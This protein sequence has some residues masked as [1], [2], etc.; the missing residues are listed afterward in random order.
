MAENN[1]NRR[2]HAAGLAAFLLLSV[3]FYWKLVLTD[4]YTWVESPDLAH[5]VLPWIQFQAGEWHAGRLPLWAPFEWGGQPL[6]GQG[7]PGVVYPLNW[8]LYLAPL[9]RGWIRFDVL[10]AYY[11]ILHA[12]AGWFMFLL[13]RTLGSTFLASLTGG[14]VFAYGGYLG[15]IDWPQMLNGAIW[16]P[17][18]ILFHWRAVRGQLPVINSIWS[19]FFLGL[20]W[21]SGHHQVPIFLTLAL[22]VS[23]VWFLFRGQLTLYAALAT[24]V[25]FPLVAAWQ[26]LPA[27]EYG[28]MA[29]RWVGLAEPVGW[30][31]AVPYFLHQKYSFQPLSVLGIVI[32]GF[33]VNTTAF[34]GAAAASLTVL[35]LRARPYFAV[36]AGAG[37]LYSLGQ[38]GVIEG[39]LYSLVPMV[40]KARSPSMAVILVSLGAGPMV[41]AG[42]DGLRGHADSVLRRVLIVSGCAILAFYFGWAALREINSIPDQRPFLSALAALGM[43]GVLGWNHVRARTVAAGLVFLELSLVATYLY[44]NR[45]DPAPASYTAGMSQHQDAVD[46]L[47]RTTA[48]PRVMI[49]NSLVPFNFGDWHGLDVYG[50]YLASL[51]A[52]VVDAGSQSAGAVRMMGVTHWLGAG[53]RDEAKTLVYSGAK[54]LNVYAYPDP[55][56]RVW[57][58]H[59][60]YRADTPAQ[61]LALIENASFDFLQGAILA[62]NL[63]MESCTG[64]HS[65]LLRQ[66]PGRVTVAADMACKG[67]LVLADVN[68]PGWKVRVDG[69]AAELLTV[70]G[71]QRG[72]ALSKGWH[73]VEFVYRPTSAILGGALTFVGTLLALGT[74]IIRRRYR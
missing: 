64:D 51:T 49:D 19:G 59:S 62:S 3:A 28:R 18:I 15:T 37:L 53:P 33:H 8:L 67:L 22:G 45:Y 50:G 9:K 63:A 4:Q 72:V 65:S 30:K 46:Y 55:L 61:Q 66:E 27:L 34:M 68:Y 7:Q 31:D 21:L 10:H 6:A 54:G 12:L 47:R 1:H 2:S 29:R 38:F 23:I 60:I 35:G 26:L 73:T 5:Q 52:N 24:G 71:M 39:L 42:L 41:A 57:T 14:M 44:P 11:V 70:N 13:C 20:A 17:L 36:L 25:V 48:N 74:S 40:E 58:V 69:E 32:P 56:P 16:A 43:A